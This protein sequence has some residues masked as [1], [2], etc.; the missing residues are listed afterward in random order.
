MRLVG[1]MNLWE[2]SCAVGITC[3]VGLRC[4]TG[5]VAMV[6]VRFVA[7]VTMAVRR[8]GF[9]NVVFPVL[10]C[11]IWGR[12]YGYFETAML[13]CKMEMLPFEVR[14]GGKWVMYFFSQQTSMLA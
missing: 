10:R 1:L 3:R 6:G 9:L 4:G 2:A 7:V 14:I 12:V 11:W 8:T 5:G 13:F